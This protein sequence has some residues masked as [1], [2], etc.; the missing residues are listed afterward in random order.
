M[1]LGVRQ[2]STNTIVERIEPTSYGQLGRRLK[3]VTGGGGVREGWRV[4][5]GGKLDSVIIASH[6]SGTIA[7]DAGFGLAAKLTLG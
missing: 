6:C 3:F 2:K 1:C 5:G 4:G 7:T